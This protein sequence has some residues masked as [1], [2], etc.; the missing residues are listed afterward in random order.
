MKPRSHHPARP[1][2]FEPT[3]PQIQHAAYLLWEEAGK[4]EGRDQEIWF[5][6]RELLKHRAAAHAAAARGPAATALSDKS[7]EAIIA[8]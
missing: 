2:V 5:A 7:V 3:E 1:P 4:P 6:A 8:D